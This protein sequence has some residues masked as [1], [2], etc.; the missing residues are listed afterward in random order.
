MKK[1]LTKKGEKMKKILLTML[2]LIALI[3]MLI[4]EDL[5]LEE[6]TYEDFLSHYLVDYKVESQIQLEGKIIDYDIANDDN[7]IVIIT[8]NQNDTYTIYYH[9]IDNNERWEKQFNEMIDCEI[10]DTGKKIRISN[11]HSITILD[12]FGNTYSE[13]VMPGITLLPSYDGEYL[14]QETNMMSSKQNELIIYD[15]NFEKLVLNLPELANVRTM[16]YRFVSENIILSVIDAYIRIYSFRNLK[17]ELLNELELDRNKYLGEL[18]GEF[19]YKLTDYS[20]DYFGL[21]VNDDGLYVFNLNGDLVYRDEKSYNQIRFLDNANII[22]SSFS[23]KNTAI[24]NLETKE[25]N[26]FDFTFQWTTEK[27]FVY[28]F[29]ETCSK[30]GNL[31]FCN[32]ETGIIEDPQYCMILNKN[33]VT[34]Q[35][36]YLSNVIV[37]T[38]G[39]RIVILSLEDNPTITYLGVK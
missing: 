15:K 27:Y 2:F 8:E 1:D 33:N 10:T 5:R 30:I 22:V 18:Y 29:L 4:S 26:E 32:A 35:I 23:N 7:S 9:D 24:I 13:K 34:S 39:S 25:K 37:A 36:D 16:R 3:S 14:Y 28:G 6:I 38:S 17:L 11:G 12:R 19:H 31:A 21:V 20:N